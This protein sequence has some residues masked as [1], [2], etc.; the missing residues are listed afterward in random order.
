MPMK[1]G[2][3]RTD[4]DGEVYRREDTVWAVE[5]GIGDDFDPGILD[6]K[7]GAIPVTDQ[8]EL[9]WEGPNPPPKPYGDRGFYPH[10]GQ[11][12]E[13]A[14]ERQREALERHYREDL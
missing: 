10:V 12:I 1:D 6:F 7:P 13:F 14:S 8:P 9:W 5:P 4:T 2:Y 11:T 3:C